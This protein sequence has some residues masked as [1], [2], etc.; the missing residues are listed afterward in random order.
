[1]H[2]FAVRHVGSSTVKE[3]IQHGA[4]ACNEMGRIVGQYG[5]MTL[6]VVAICLSM[7]VLGQGVYGQSW[8]FGAQAG[9]GGEDQAKAVVTDDAGNHY[10]TGFF[11]G[12]ISFGGG[13]T[14][15][16]A[17]SDIFIAKYNHSG[18]LLWA[19][20]VTC[21]GSDAGMDLAL[22]EN[23]MLYATGWF[24]GVASFQ[25]GSSP[26]VL[27][28]TGLQDIFVA[29][30]DPFTGDALWAVKAGG[31]QEDAGYSLTAFGGG[32]YLA[33]SFEGNA[34]FDGTA[35]S[36]SGGSDGFLARLNANTG[37]FDW[38]VKGVCTDDD[39][40]TKVANDGT[41]LYV[42]GFYSNA[43]Y[44][45]GLDILLLVGGK[46]GRLA[47]Y[48][49]G[50]GLV[51]QRRIG[52]LLN[53]EVGTGVAVANGKVFV[54]ANSS[55][56]G[57]PSFFG[58]LLGSPVTL[59]GNGSNFMLARYDAVSG[60]PDWVMGG[61]YNG[62]DYF[63]DVAIQ[64]DGNVLVAGSFEDSV[65]FGSLSTLGSNHEAMVVEFLPDGSF[66]RIS[67]AGGPMNDAAYGV[68]G[69]TCG[70]V[71][72][73][74]MR[75]AFSAPPVPFTPAVGAGDL[76]M[77][78]RFPPGILPATSLPAADTVCLYDSIALS[79][80]AGFSNVQWQ[81][82]PSATG[83]WTNI[84]GATN[85]TYMAKPS[86]DTWY[87]ATAS[88]A[89]DGS[90]SVSFL[91][92]ES[93]P[94]SF[95]HLNLNYC[96]NA[97]PLALA[98]SMAP[99]GS[100]TA[101]LPGLTDFGN[102]T[103]EYLPSG[104]FTGMV[105]IIYTAPGVC[106]VPDTQS[107]RID[108]L[109][110]PSVSGLPALT[111]S[112]MAP[113][114]VTGNIAPLGSF[115]AT[116]TAG[117]LDNGDGTAYFN[118]GAGIVGATYQLRYSVTD[119]HGCSAFTD[120][121]TVLRSSKIYSFTGLP[122]A[123]CDNGEIVGLNGSQSPIG[124][125]MANAGGLVDSANGNAS[126]N[127]LLA[128]LGSVTVTYADTGMCV[129]GDTQTTIVN[130]APMVGF[131]GLQSTYCSDFTP[132]TLVGNF[133]GGTF[134]SS[135]GGIANL[136]PGLAEFDPGSATP[137]VLI[138]VVYSYTDANFCTD[139]DTQRVSVTM[140]R[141]LQMVTPPTA[142]CDNEGLVT[143]T[144]NA[145]PSGTFTGTGL[146]LTDNGNGTAALDPSLVSGGAIT[147]VYSDT[148]YCVT[149]DTVPITVHPAPVA[150]FSGLDNSYCNDGD[151][152]VLTGNF[153]PLGGFGTT[154]GLVDNG[155]GTA[156]LD[157][158]QIAAGTGY[159]ISYSYTDG[160]GCTDGDTLYFSV[161]AVMN[162]SFTG[163]PSSVCADA[164]VIQLAGSQAPVGGFS[165]GSNALTDQGN[166]AGSFDPSLAVTGVPIE[167]IYN[168]G[169]ACAVG[170][171]QVIQVNAVPN[172][173]LTGLGTQYCAA[174]GMVTLSGSP[175]AGGQFGPVLAGL[176]DLGNGSAQ[177]D[178]GQVPADVALTIWYSVTDGNGCSGAD[179]ASTYVYSEPVAVGGDDDTLCVGE[180]VS[181]G[182][183]AH[184]G[185]QYVWTAVPGGVVSNQSILLA[186]PV[187]NTLYVLEVSHGTCVDKDSVAVRVTAIPT[188][189]AGE[190]VEVCA[191][192]SV[193]LIGVGSA[194]TLVWRDLSGNIVGN[195][196]VLEV[197]AQ[198]G[199][200]YSLEV[201]NADGCI[202][203]D[204]VAVGAVAAPG[205]VDAGDDQRVTEGGP[206][207]LGATVPVAGNGTWSSTGTLI[208]QDPS[209]AA[210]SVS[211]LSLGTNVLIWTVS[212]APCAAVSDTV[213]I[214]RE[215]FLI[216]SGFSPN[217]DGVNDLF[218]IRGLESL[219]GA[220]LT[221]FNRW[222]NLEVEIKTYRND[223]DGRN[224]AGSPLMDDTYYYVL[225]TVDGGNY[226]G[227]V[228]IKR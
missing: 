2:Y 186:A 197:V 160:N 175:G 111:C 9:S 67:S 194:P 187:T 24:S 156:S 157:P 144:G 46:D 51:W 159:P 14:F 173:G 167:V 109:P 34:N 54:A 140:R 103:A 71:S 7:L 19:R 22:D 212:N 216:P 168:G 10:V 3:C 47:K 44:S 28:A 104:A 116:P 115:S 137:V 117:W 79:I 213:L 151:V 226:S 195:G 50:G 221:I 53:D 72:C 110:V 62:D 89:C 209:S 5:V 11:T 199:M 76:W 68:D 201:S 17:G 122:S 136:S 154:T 94:V 4:T 84:N 220:K 225:N 162:Y 153:A 129:V 185:H 147:V 141:N 174:D 120:V 70:W 198:G 178:P 101:S 25:T 142:L 16:S 78:G 224:G 83:P 98:G 170:D 126:F 223:W 100:F 222:G 13:N 41:H 29:K 180:S 80:G 155:N 45:V 91:H 32:V 171:T 69:G 204:T 8:S 49:T 206:V 96:A 18:T 202:A 214:L 73:G 184:A 133:L 114:L 161:V 31:N 193:T 188:V 138:D 74:T 23:G 30:F 189:D 228:V 58:L 56:A 169:A 99:L 210:T 60:E 118:P 139:T 124:K 82:G 97:G 108:T 146:G 196:A 128:P 86:T 48:D 42:S 163:L 57:I 43:P 87:R 176:N 90:S 218:V 164:P 183:P 39:A 203:L 93:N 15:T 191:G 152:D 75:G 135:G 6:V 121:N 113:L 85:T 112:A 1:M 61:G 81:S 77:A 130:L 55:G 192:D 35:L 181:L 211:G 215:D 207:V 125:F 190:D 172:V 177:F 37:A 132:D 106:I 148:G 165:S 150:S 208:F 95:T 102:G 158:S 182:A 52:S 64:A 217:G 179:S 200:S 219:G 123:L 149:G 59:S 143:L 127:P 134:S 26:L 205:P 36:T 145:A 21:N 40:F 107:T 38:A 92:V 105:E 63:E 66:V 20:H 12:I 227:Y 88:N 27:S 166:G 33:G 131:A 65:R 119:G